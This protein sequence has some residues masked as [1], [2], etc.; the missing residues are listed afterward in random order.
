MHRDLKPENVMVNLQPLSAT[1]IDFNRAYPLTQCTK[2]TCR[3]TEGYFPQK[4][5]LRDGSTKWDIWSLGA[6]VL[7]ADLGINEYLRV[8]SENG[9]IFKAGKYLREDKPHRDIAAII[10]GTI[11]AGNSENLMSLGEIINHLKTSVFRRYV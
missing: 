10:N 7:E 4:E 11:L 8:N 3:G 9:A 2:G 1:L 6:M 5:D